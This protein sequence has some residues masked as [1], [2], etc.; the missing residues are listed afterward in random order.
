MAALA[1]T[2]LHKS[3]HETRALAGVSFDVARGEILALLGPSGCGKSTLLNVIA[4][5]EEPDAGEVV[6]EGQPL[7]G[8]PPHQRGF[9][10]MFQDYLLF[11][12]LNVEQNVAFGLRFIGGS[13]QE[14]RERVQELLAL[15]G[16][17]GFAQRDVSTLSGGEQQRVALARAL[18]PQPRLLML[19]EPLGALDR[20][21][22]ERL[23]AELHEVL[24][25]LEQTAIY[26][27]HD[28]EEAF[29]MA[30]RVV[31]LRAG[32]VEQIG[33]PQEIYRTPASVFIARFLGLENLLE[34]QVSHMGEGWV[35]ETEVGRLPLPAAPSQARTPGKRT[36]LIR[37]DGARLAQEGDGARLAG[38]ARAVSFRGSVQRL[39]VSVNGVLL[40]FDFPG[41]ASL[42]GA[43]EAVWL[44]IPPEAIQLF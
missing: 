15:V 42:P 14:K 37:P 35:I 11:P 30:D 17:P 43:G 1:L 44:A 33:T 19:D 38:F 28:Q 13:A 24:R 23:L 40:H 18:A 4:G 29:A 5:L 3:Y 12:H 16:L 9:G 21:L 39:G 20:A 25:R 10:L 26:V 2:N 22:R 27:T 36:V 6:W 8:I 7:A 31:I 34:G 41:N 32:E